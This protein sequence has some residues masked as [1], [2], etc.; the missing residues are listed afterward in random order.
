MVPDRDFH[1]DLANPS[2]PFKLLKNIPFLR[3]LG[4]VVLDFVC[5][6]KLDLHGVYVKD[7]GFIDEVVEQSLVHEYFRYGDHSM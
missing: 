3:V 2:I 6:G 1:R 5:D 4:K 7:V